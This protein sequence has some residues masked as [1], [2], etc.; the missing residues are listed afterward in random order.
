MAG[1]TTACLRPLRPSSCQPR[2][3]QLLLQRWPSTHA[4]EGVVSA[5]ATAAAAAARRLVLPNLQRFEQV[6]AS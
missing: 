2:R 5:V 4:C 6:A 1:R 3:C